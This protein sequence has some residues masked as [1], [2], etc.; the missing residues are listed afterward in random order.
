ML[1]QARKT[2]FFPLAYTFDILH[3]SYLCANLVAALACLEVHDFSHCQTIG[4][5]V[6]ARYE[7]ECCC[8]TSMRTHRL[9][10]ADA[11]FVRRDKKFIV[12][13]CVHRMLSLTI[14]CAVWGSS[15]DW[16]R[17]FFSPKGFFVT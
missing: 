9:A 7:D 3:P 15:D 4:I 8:S 17:I 16:L 2:Y 11:T 6:S 14:G 5:T 13:G 10:F 12:L 1:L